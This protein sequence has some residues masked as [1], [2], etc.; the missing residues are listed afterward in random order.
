MVVAVSVFRLV[1]LGSINPTPSKNVPYH[2][3]TAIAI[4]KME[5]K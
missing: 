5:A 2:N 3:R 4:P 1:D